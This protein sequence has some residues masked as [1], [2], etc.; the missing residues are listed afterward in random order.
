MQKVFEIVRAFKEYY[1]ID[2]RIILSGWLSKA[3][4][5]NGNWNASVPF[6]EKIGKF[7]GV[8]YGFRIRATGEMV[9]SGGEYLAVAGKSDGDIIYYL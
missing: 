6:Y 5:L 7:A 3:D 2:D 8:E 4:C 9:Y 1:R